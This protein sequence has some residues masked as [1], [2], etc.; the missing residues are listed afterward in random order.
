MSNSTASPPAWAR[1]TFYILIIIVIIMC[2]G[3]FV[4]KASFVAG[5]LNVR[6]ASEAIVSL[7]IGLSVICAIIW[8]GGITGVT[9]VSQGV[10]KALW[11]TFVV[12]ILSATVAVY[13]GFFTPHTPEVFRVSGVVEKQ[14]DQTPNDIEIS[15]CFPPYYPIH[16]T[17][18]NVNLQISKD[19]EG[20]FPTLA[21]SHPAYFTESIDLNDRDKVDLKKDQLTILTPVELKPVPH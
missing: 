11:L 20:K 21:F 10:Q 5:D 6:T 8:V 19:P 2:I 13:K 1:N 3:T 17:K 4:L 9:T 7:C 12:A 16:S 15:T 14:D 18:K